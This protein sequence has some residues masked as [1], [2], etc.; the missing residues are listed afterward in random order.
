MLTGWRAANT[1][2][3][4]P[5]YQTGVFEGALM[6]CRSRARRGLRLEIAL[7]RGLVINARNEDAGEHAENTPPDLGTIAYLICVEF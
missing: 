3:I 1:Q 7:L 5:T 2:N 6:G 4:H